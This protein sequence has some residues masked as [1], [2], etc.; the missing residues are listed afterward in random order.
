MRKIFYTIFILLIMFI[1][2]GVNAQPLPPVLSLP[3]DY[4]TNV[5]LFPTF[6]WQASSG[7][8]SYRLQIWKSSEVVFDVSGL[9]G[10]S[11][12]LTA[13]V[14]EGNT[15]Y[16]WRMNAT[17]AAGTSQWSG[18]FHFTTTVIVPDPPTLVSPMND[19]VNV[20]LNPCLDWT[21]VSAA[22]QYRVQVSTSTN[23]GT[24]V[25]DVGGLTNSSYCIQSGVLAFSTVYYWHVQASNSGGGSWS[26]TWNFTT[27]PAPPSPP[28]L[29][30]PANNSTGIPTTLTFRWR[31]SVGATGYHIQVSLNQTFQALVIDEN[32]TD[33]LYTVPSGILSGSTPYYWRVKASNVGGPSEYSAYW[34]FTTG[35]APPAAPV[36][37]YPG[38]HDTAIAVSGILFSWNTVAGANSYRIQ[39]SISNAFT[40]TIVN[41]STGSQT[42]YLHNTPALANNTTYY[43]R[44][45]ATN[46]GGTGDWSQIWDFKTIMSAPPAPTLI[47]PTNGAT[48]V[49][50]TPTMDWSDV[51]GATSYRLQIAT[52]ASFTSPVL[53]VVVGPGSQ[54]TVPS[55]IL[56]G[57]THYYWRVASINNGGQ[58]VWSSTFNFWTL[59]TFTL[60]LK[61][62]LEGFYNGTAQVPDTVKVFLANATSFAL[63]D[64]SSA[65]LGTDGVCN[66]VSFARASSGNYWIVVKHRNHL[67][68][69]SSLV[70]YF[71]T[72]VPVAYDFTT[73][74]SQAYGNNMKQVGSVWVFIGGDANQDGF[75]NGS[76]YDV[77]RTQFGYDGYRSCD[78]NG[79]TFVDG[80]D[81]PILNNNFGQYTKRPY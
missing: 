80:Y 66:G 36:L 49:I 44:V 70:K 22:T 3:G 50:L 32:V 16:Y 4:A 30:Y 8:T 48:N 61:I 45:N 33:T 40:T 67:E 9:T 35:V 72:G 13:A 46:S 41:V 37:V 43:W 39:I 26:V 29:Y 51:S 23:F 75:V 27:V 42:Q 58:G 24:T 2:S 77:F 18:N 15:F 19:S 76:D 17:G 52:N 69:W 21:D 60:N 12:N 55:G 31:K 62:F 65:I 68:T 11:Y 34:K 59:Q 73:G 1:T 74:A 53:N 25:L 38:N 54:F 79:D 20:G 71:T 81:L 64:T 10:T 56:Q 7:A 57:Y 47:F 28:V 63:A 78:F 14:L 6:Q 5:S